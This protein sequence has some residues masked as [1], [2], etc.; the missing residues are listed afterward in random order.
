[1]AHSGELTRAIRQFAECNFNVKRTARHLDLHINTVSC[2]L[3]RSAE[4]SRAVV[5]D[6]MMDEDSGKAG[7]HP[8]A[9]SERDH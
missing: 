1:L 3:N 4:L 9:G 2:R 7:S 6:Q 5:V 8:C